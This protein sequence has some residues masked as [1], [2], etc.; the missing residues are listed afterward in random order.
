MAAAEEERATAGHD[1]AR[2]EEAW[3]PN[4]HI[5]ALLLFVALFA[6]ASIM[7][8]LARAAAMAGCCASSWRRRRVTIG[9]SGAGN[10]HARV[11]R[12]VKA[13]HGACAAENDD[14]IGVVFIFRPARDVFVAIS[15]PSIDG[16]R[17]VRIDILYL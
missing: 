1:G 15:R 14:C 3:L 8:R 12:S 6:R 4:A 17:L 7:H 16:V 2:R 10:C 11:A 5:I 13:C 9:R